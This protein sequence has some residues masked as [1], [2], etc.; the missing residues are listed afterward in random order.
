M[1]AERQ[2]T[3]ARDRLGLLRRSKTVKSS[4]AERACMPST[5]RTD[6]WRWRWHETEVDSVAFPDR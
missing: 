5:S 1:F 6:A 2:Y 4:L 3:G